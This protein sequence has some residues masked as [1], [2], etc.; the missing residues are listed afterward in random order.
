LQ[1]LPGVLRSLRSAPGERAIE[2][3]GISFR[4]LFPRI[5][6]APRDLRCPISI[7]NTHR[8][9]HARPNPTRAGLL[10][11]IN[12][13]GRFDISGNVVTVGVQAVES[14]P[15]AFLTIIQ[16]DGTFRAV[17]RL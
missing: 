5:R 9:D 1:V 14:P 17:D 10:R 16:Q 2:A 15:K 8:L 11:A 6:Q 12:D 4:G 7:S 13:I 3:A